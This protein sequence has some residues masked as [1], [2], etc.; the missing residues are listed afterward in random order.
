M[1]DVALGIMTRYDGDARN[2]WRDQTPN[3]VVKRLKQIKLGTQRAWMTA[4]ALVDTNQI[5]GEGNIK[6]DTHTRKVLGRVF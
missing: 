5:K 1:W 6:A 3:E 4:G 2:I